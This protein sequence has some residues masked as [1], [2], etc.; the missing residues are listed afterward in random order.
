IS[1]P[2]RESRGSLLE[3]T[4]NA[5]EPLTLDDGST[6]GFLEDGDTVTMTAWAPG[7]DGARIGIAEVTGTILPAR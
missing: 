2:T 7:P 6:R 1:G 5:T 3:L 4:W